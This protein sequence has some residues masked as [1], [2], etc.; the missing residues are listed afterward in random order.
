MREKERE[1]EEREIRGERARA[2]GGEKKGEKMRARKRE[3][4]GEKMRERGEGERGKVR[5]RAQI[6]PGMGL[7]EVRFRISLRVGC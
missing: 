1:G 2:R 3:R 4:G 7:S 6:N 5:F